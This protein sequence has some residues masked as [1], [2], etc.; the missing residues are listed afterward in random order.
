MAMLL[1]WAAW[2]AL[3]AGVLAVLAYGL[4]RVYRNPHVAHAMWVI[5]LIKLVT[6]PIVPI[7]TGFLNL[8]KEAQSSSV[9]AGIS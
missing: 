5:V 7:P 9:M 1:S 8:K 3:I 6:P 4:T 2:N